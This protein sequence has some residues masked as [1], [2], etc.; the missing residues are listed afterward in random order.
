MESSLNDFVFK[1]ETNAA[2]DSP[3]I[4][5]LITV[6]RNKVGVAVFVFTQVSS[7]IL[8]RKMV[9]FPSHKV[10]LREQVYECGLK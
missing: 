5:R 3:I 2:F 9:S 7:L 6:P 4:F 8:K 1:N 10:D